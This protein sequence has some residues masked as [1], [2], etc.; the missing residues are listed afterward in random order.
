M[1]KKKFINNVYIEGYL[2][3]SNLKEKVA[4]ANSK[5]PGAH[6]INGEIK[7]A[8]D[9][10]CLNIVPI[11]FS[12]VPESRGEFAILRDIMN[13][14]YSSVTK[15]GKDDATKLNVSTAIAINDFVSPSTGEMVSALRNE[16]GFIHVVSQLPEE[17]KRN[18]FDVDIVITGVKEVD[19]NPDREIPA[20]A[21]VKGVIFDFTKAIIPVEFAVYSQD[22]IG[23]F[24]SFADAKEFPLF[25]KV[26]GKQI[27]QHMTRKYEE[28]SAFGDPVVKEITS[29]RK[30]YVITSAQTEPYVFDDESTI[31]MSELSEWSSN[32]EVVLAKVRASY[33]ERTGK[34][35]KAA[36]ADSSSV[37]GG[38]DDEFK[39]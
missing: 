7:I 11:H 18:S 1:S 38:S 35:A 10:A 13:D 39:F 16:G 12:Y 5:V 3:E 17:S 23:Y 14:V 22:G 21:I 26:H 24:M 30:E 6:Y 19:E 37:I 34:N 27:V 9:E 33:D 4:G 2:Y 31:L 28:A 29:T 36:G 32:R 15:K 20:H 8:T 25:T